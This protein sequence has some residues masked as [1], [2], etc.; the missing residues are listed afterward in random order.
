MSFAEPADRYNSYSDTVTIVLLVEFS[1]LILYLLFAFVRW[2]RRRT[3][4]LQVRGF[5]VFSLLAAFSSLVWVLP[6]TGKAKAIWALFE[7]LPD[8]FTFIA[9]LFLLYHR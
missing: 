8:V 5:Y 7:F 6:D 9:A 3:I 1:L 4:K 2:E